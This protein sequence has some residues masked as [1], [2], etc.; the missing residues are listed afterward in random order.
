MNRIGQ[1]MLRV[2]TPSTTS[3]DQW[4]R[5]TCAMMMPGAVGVAESSA[6][7]GYDENLDD[8]MGWDGTRFVYVKDHEGLITTTEYYE[9]GAI[10]Y[11]KSQS[12]LKGQAGG[13]VKLQELEYVS[14]TANSQT[15]YLVSKEHRYPSDA[16]T[17]PVITTEY[18]YTFY[19]D[20]LQVKE[21]TTTWPTIPTGQ[22]GSGSATQLIEVFDE[23]NNL[24]WSKDERGFITHITYNP[25]TG[26]PI[27][28]IDDV[29]TGA[30]SGAP[31]GWTTP[32]G[33]GLNL[34]TNFESDHHGRITRT[35]DPV[36][37]IDI[38]GTAT[39][40]RRTTWTV[41]QDAEHQR[42]SGAGYLQTSNDAET[43]INPVSITKVNFNGAP[44]DEI[45]AVRA[46]TAGP[47]DLGLVP[48]VKLRG[49]EDLS[50]QRLLQADFV[51]ALSHDSFLWETDRRGP[52]TTKRPTAMISGIDKP[53]PHPPVARFRGRSS[54]SAACPVEPMSARM[55]T[56]YADRSDRRRSNP[57]NNMVSVVLNQ[58]DGGVAGGDGNLT[59]VTQMVDNSTLRVMSYG[60]DWRDRRVTAA[61]AEAYFE[62]W[63][64]DNLNRMT[65]S[66]RYNTSESGPLLSRN[67]TLYD[68]LSRV[69][70]CVS[71]AVDS[72]G[73]VGSC[74]DRQS[75]VR[76]GW[77]PGEVPAFRFVPLLQDTVRQPQSAQS[78]ICGLRS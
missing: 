19:P 63:T 50:I 27:Q 38:A 59:Q 47:L 72:S 13:P 5:F 25:A 53:G 71:Y 69:Y 42:W 57:S 54:I 9:D 39:E 30:V 2:E 66:E 24:I 11:M 18:G 33:G 15:I 31:A 44:T 23:F 6:I 17:S 28:R 26:A 21:K 58:Y 16:G 56:R 49:L 14:Q 10:G 36:Q 29:D 37:T 34:V 43:L 78:T 8:L 55:M 40:V 75:L 35:L 61:G 51:A 7:S 22:N 1:E 3:S 4:L 67:D 64:Y 73:T 70:Q 12:L 46:S 52:I 76:P 32:S 41:Y 68:D 60:Y 48:A 65:R 77:E 74:A 20:T 45:L 62:K